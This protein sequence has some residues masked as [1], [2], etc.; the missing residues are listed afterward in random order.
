ETVCRTLAAM[1]KDGVL[2]LRGK[3]LEVLDIDRLTEEAGVEPAP[4]PIT[5]RATPRSGCAFS[6]VTAMPIRAGGAVW[7]SCRAEAARDRIDLRQ[8]AA[9]HRCWNLIDIAWRRRDDDNA[10]SCGFASG[11]GSRAT[12]IWGSSETGKRGPE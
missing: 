9:A 1:R 4:P 6:A 8:S 12:W 10:C 7:T 11:W 3:R 2:I 5:A